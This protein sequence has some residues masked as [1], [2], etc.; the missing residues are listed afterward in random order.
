MKRLVAYVFIVLVMAS[1]SLAINEQDML[2]FAGNWW[3]QYGNDFFSATISSDATCRKVLFTQ[4]CCVPMNV[5]RVGKLDLCQRDS[6]EVVIFAGHKQ[7]AKCRA[8]ITVK[9]SVDAGGNRID[10][11]LGPHFI[12]CSGNIKLFRK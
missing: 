7:V 12:G 10:V 9:F 2:K 5:D 11:D 4:E 8:G 3:A 1:T 6:G